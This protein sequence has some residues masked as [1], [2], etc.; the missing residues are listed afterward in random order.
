MV[1]AVDILFVIELLDGGGLLAVRKA[2]KN[3][4]HAQAD[5]SGVVAL[6]EHV[7]LQIGFVVEDLFEVPGTGQIGKALEVQ[8]RRSGGGDERR[9][10]S[11]RDAGHLLEQRDILRMAAKLVVADQRAK[12]SAAERAVL[13]LINLLEDIALIELDCFVE[14]LEQIVL[15]DIHQLDLEVGGGFR[16]LHKVVQ[17]A[18]RGFELLERLGVHHLVEL[19]GNQRVELGDAAVDRHLDVFRDGHLTVHDVLDEV[20]QPELSGAPFLGA[21]P[22]PSFFDDPVDNAS[23]LYSGF[24][25][26]RR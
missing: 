12:R 9:V 13:F 10:R 1:L 26:L 3:V 6:A 2:R 20:F 19:P 22:D 15:A 14:I 7:P 5:V 16:L 25:C 23:V 21:L 11:R 4:R 8:Q 24:G 18:P 17:T